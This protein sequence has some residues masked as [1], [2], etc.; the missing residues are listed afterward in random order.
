M[1]QTCLDRTTPI[2]RERVDVRTSRVGH[3][4]S[5][6]TCAAQSTR[7]LQRTSMKLFCSESV[8]WNICSTAESR[9][10]ECPD[11]SWLLGTPSKPPT[12]SS[13]SHLRSRLAFRCSNL[14]GDGSGIHS[15]IPICVFSYH[16][17]ISG[18]H[19]AQQAAQQ[20]SGC[21]HEGVWGLKQCRQ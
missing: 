5:G 9:P 3:G 6:R 18:G 13:N 4:M 19:Y 10:R 8:P 7:T 21:V 14:S 15:S 20:A 12:N 16:V 1:Q 2:A 11:L 17:Q